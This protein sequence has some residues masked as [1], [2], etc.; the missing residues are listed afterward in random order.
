MNTLF[1]KQLGSDMDLRHERFEKTTNKNDI[2]N[3]IILASSIDLKWSCDQKKL[4]ERR[5]YIPFATEFRSYYN[6]GII[7]LT[8]MLTLV[9]SLVQRAACEAG[10]IKSFWY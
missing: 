1:Y 9:F 7:T 8:E 3:D 6:S 5:K 2:I 4:L 10:Q